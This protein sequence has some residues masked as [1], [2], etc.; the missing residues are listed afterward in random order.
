MPLAV[1]LAPLPL[2][3][4]PEPLLLA[5]P[6]E[7]PVELWLAAVPCS[8]ELCAEL[9]PLGLVAEEFDCAWGEVELCGSV[10]LGLVLFGD[11]ELGEAVLGEVE[12]CGSVELGLVLLGEVLLG[13]VELCGSVELGLVLLGDVEL[14]EALW[15]GEVELGL[16]LL[17]LVLLGEVVLW[18]DGLAVL[19]PVWSVELG[20]LLLGDVLL[21]PLVEE[22]GLAEF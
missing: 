22:L 9:D 21:W 8:V 19:E 16:V 15:S 20:L 5:A 10:E 12:L 4:L 3:A 17:G 2:L 18:P 7:L 1:V 14:G 11:V 6:A 13:E